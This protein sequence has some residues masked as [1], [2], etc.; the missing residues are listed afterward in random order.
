MSPRSSRSIPTQKARRVAGLSAELSL[1]SVRS[2]S[3][4]AETK[5][6]EAEQGECAGF[7]DCPR[8]HRRQQQEIACFG[9][10]RDSERIDSTRRGGHAAKKSRTAPVEIE[11]CGLTNQVLCQIEFRSDV[12]DPVCYVAEPESSVARRRA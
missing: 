6:A 7:G 3:R 10:G 4:Q 2:A 1:S 12:P 5:Q 9:I 11:E 8:R